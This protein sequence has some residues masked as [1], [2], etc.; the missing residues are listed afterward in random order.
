MRKSF[1]FQR[2]TSLRTL[3]ACLGRGY[4]DEIVWLDWLRSNDLKRSA[5]EISI[6]FSHDFC[7]VCGTAGSFLQ[8]EEPGLFIVPFAGYVV[9]R[10]NLK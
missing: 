5:T 9:K 8:K 4:Y 2:T 3:L 10:L 1:R 6:E 7:T